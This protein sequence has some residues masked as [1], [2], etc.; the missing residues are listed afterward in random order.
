MTTTIDFL[1][2][3]EPEGGIR[4]RGSGVDDPLS[5]KGWNQMWTAVDGMGPWDAVYTSPMKRCA[6]FAQVLCSRNRLPLTEDARLREVGFGSWE[7]HSPKDLIRAD[8]KAF[9]RFF[10]DAIAARP[11]DAEP[12][13]GF[14][15]RICEAITDIVQAHPDTHLLLVVHA[16]VMRMAMAQCLGIPLQTIYRIRIKNAGFL[17]LRYTPRGY[18][19][20]VH[21]GERSFA[22]RH[23][24]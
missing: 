23:S 11:K 3:G 4:Y 5:D 16:G 12:L 6:S 17:R 13:D 1:R 24:D 7:G 15:T 21:M 14:Y 9:Y 18:A 19:E 10:D 2:H 20:L 22:F 8:P